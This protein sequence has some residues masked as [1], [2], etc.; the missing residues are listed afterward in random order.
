MTPIEICNIGLIALG[1]RHLIQSFDDG[2]VAAECAKATFRAH[3]DAVLTEAPWND[4]TAS[5]T[6]AAVADSQYR[7]V[8]PPDLLSVRHVKT[9]R[10]WRREGRTIVTKQPPPITIT[11]TRALWDGRMA[12]EDIPLSPI[13][14][15][16]IAYKFASAA[17]MRITGNQNDAVLAERR[18]TAAVAQAWSL[19]AIERSEQREAV[20]SW[21]D[22]EHHEP[23]DLTAYATWWE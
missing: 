19:N 23:W 18:Y 3:M 14:A 6:L 5:E 10:P 17:A 22:P 7:Y 12:G 2:G 1:D 15:Q 8:L 11:Y 9:P 13:L 20:G 21:I 4:A 16:A